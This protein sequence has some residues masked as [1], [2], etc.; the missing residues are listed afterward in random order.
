M[1]A[2]LVC[3]LRYFTFSDIRTHAYPKIPKFSSI[4]LR[5]SFRIDC[6]VRLLRELLQWISIRKYLFFPFTMFV[7]RR[8]KLGKIIVSTISLNFLQTKL[9]GYYLQITIQSSY[10]L[11]T[12]ATCNFYQSQIQKFVFKQI[13]FA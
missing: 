3:V 4:E 12:L 5:I 8:T 13:D 7:A 11:T 2:V 6:V 10:V 1:I 9:D